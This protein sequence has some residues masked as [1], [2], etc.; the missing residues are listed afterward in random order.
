[1]PRKHVWI[2]AIR[3]KNKKSIAVPLAPAA[4][5]V[6]RTVKGNHPLYVFSYEDGPIPAQNGYVWKQWR[7][8]VTSAELAPLRFHDLR[9][10]FASWHIQNGTPPHILQELGGWSSY[11]VMRRYAHLDA[12]HLAKWAHNI[13]HVKKARSR[14]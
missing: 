11:D 2:A 5:R 14:K 10:T 13:G 12:S 4:V 9:H 1:M 8:A 7:T 6:L 3:S